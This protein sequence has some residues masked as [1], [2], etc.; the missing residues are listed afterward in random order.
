ML[1]KAAT[2]LTEFENYETHGAYEKSLTQKI[3]VMN[4]IMSY[5]GIFLTA[6]VY[7]P[8]GKIIVPYLD[9]FNVAVRP[10]AEDEKQLHLN[11]ASSNW[12][13]NPDR[14]RKQ[15]IYFTVTAQV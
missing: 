4:F 14:L 15:V 3:F 5:L 10:F 2:R 8:F 9:V 13:I 11:S 7:V 6:F 1:T 12:T